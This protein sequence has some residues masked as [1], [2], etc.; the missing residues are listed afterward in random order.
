MKL[1]ES[2]LILN[3]DGSVYHLSLK[4][5]D[6]GDIIITVGDPGRVHRVSQ[7]FESIDF[8]MNK[9]EFITHTGTYNKKKVTV[10][11]S[12][13]GTDNVEILMNELDALVNVDLKKREV[14]KEK[15]SLDIIR[16]GTA[17]GIQNDMPLGSIIYNHYGFGLDTLMS[18]YNYEESASEIQITSNLQKVLDL[19]FKPYI[20]KCSD[21]LRKKFTN[22][23]KQGN[24]I[25]APGF[26]APQGRSIRLQ[27]KFEKMLDKL[28]F[29]H[30]KG[31]WL[32]N[33][34]METAAY[35]AMGR[36]L[37]HE[38]LSICTIVADRN[39]KKFLKNYNNVI[40]QMIVD[41]LSKI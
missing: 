33:F 27:P 16:L 1:A 12:G 41:L 37:G 2:E 3:K 7:H 10:I 36:L 40:D 26:Y 35:Y 18:F 15:K 21:K 22:G 11:S 32:T 25:T 34:D 8:E 31:L 19:P 23:Y 14:K 29:F 9:R 28:T 39:S 24:A 30:E 38:T 13:M 4:P 20:G 17:G 6:I 5:E